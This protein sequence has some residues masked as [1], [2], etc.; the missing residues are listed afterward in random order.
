MIES[1]LIAPAKSKT[2]G[3]LE[4]TEKAIYPDIPGKVEVDYPGVDGYMN[5]DYTPVLEGKKVDLKEANE[6]YH[7]TTPEN[8][9][10]ILESGEVKAYNPEDDYPGAE[11]IKTTKI[12]LSA[13]PANTYGGG[14][15]FVWNHSSPEQG[16]QPYKHSIKAEL[17]PV[18]YYNMDEEPLVR[19]YMENYLN[20]NNKNEARAQL[21]VSPLQYRNEAEV[22]ALGDI[23]TPPKRVE[24][25]IMRDIDKYN[26]S[27]K[28]TGDDFVRW[29]GYSMNYD[30]FWTFLQSWFDIKDKLREKNMQGTEFKLRSC[31]ELV[32]IGFGRS[33]AS[34]KPKDIFFRTDK[35]GLKQFSE[36]VNFY[37]QLDENGEHEFDTESIRMVMDDYSDIDGIDQSIKSEMAN[38]R[39]FKCKC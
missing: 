37:H 21:G 19:Q 33:S 16:E 2:Y 18:V 3:E 9:V 1:P 13:S 28:M 23:E 15:R 38:P 35:E 10:K 8:A 11:G 20:I 26:C 25:W 36:A 34:G 30:K 29:R 24:L 14:V 22:M 31:F 7:R 5:P 4:I 17:E 27:C 6:L 12:S 32:N 39:T